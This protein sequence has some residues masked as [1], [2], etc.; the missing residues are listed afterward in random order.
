VVNERDPVADPADLVDPDDLFRV[1]PDKFTAARNALAKSL[2]ATDKTKAAEVSKR[3]RPSATAWALNVIAHDDP[4]LI[5][6]LLAAADELKAALASGEGEAV[7][8]AQ[9]EQ[10][11][12]VEDIVQAATRQLAAHGQSTSATN[13]QRLRSTVQAAV[14]DDDIAEVL[15]AGRLDRDFEASGFG[16][17]GTTAT[18]MTGAKPRPKAA[19][20]ASGERASETEDTAVAAAHAPDE[21]ERHRAEEAARRR[22]LFRERHEKLVDAAEQ[23]EAEAAELSRVATEREA[24][25][26]D[27][28]REAAAAREA[29]D[30]A[31]AAASAARAKA[32]A[33]RP[34]E[35][36]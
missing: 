16:F 35:T 11:T 25:L 10:R 23:L 1:E 20:P 15:R 29:A 18:P 3:K 26:A 33:A 4:G 30:R 9:R 21:R 36:D 24:A 31:V 2:K 7:R 6:R 14:V 5:D 22:R 28:Q 17:A 13:D 12:R 8:E 19:P 27:A 34:D 32:D